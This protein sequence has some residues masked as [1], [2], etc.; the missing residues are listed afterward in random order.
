M[1]AVDLDDLLG[2]DL[3]RQ[4]VREHRHRHRQALQEVA[5]DRV[6][7]RRLR[8]AGL[9]A[10]LGQVL[11]FQAQ[12]VRTRAV[13][14]RVTAGFELGNHRLA[15]AAVAGQRERRN[16][17]VGWQHAGVHQRTHCQHEGA[18]VAA[19]HRDALAGADLLTLAAHQLGQAVGPVVGGTER[20][21]G[22]DHAGIGVG[23]QRHRLAR[24]HVG[25]AQEGNV[26]GVQKACSLGRV[27]ALVIGNAQQF[28][29]GTTGKIVKQPETGGAFLTIDEHFENHGG[30]AQ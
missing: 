9:H 4:P 10:H 2:A 18:G 28:H 3:A 14:L 21:A 13:Q 17:V 5:D 8:Q 25:Q 20:R 26:G 22:V 12:R 15:A 16:R 30:L 29:V 6:E 23:Y 11:V 1:L 7:D 27:L 19:R 24:G